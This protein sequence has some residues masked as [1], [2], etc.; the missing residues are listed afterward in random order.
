MLVMKFTQDPWQHGRYILEEAGS[1][2]LRMIDLFKSQPQWRSLI[3]SDRRG[4]YRLRL[5]RD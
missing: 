2:L 1:N 5:T 4:S 3:E